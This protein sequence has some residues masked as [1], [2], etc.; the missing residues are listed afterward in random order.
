MAVTH[1]SRHYFINNCFIKDGFLLKN[2]NKISKKPCH[3]IQGRHDVICPP[4]S[5]YKLSKIWDNSA[6]KLVEDGAHSGFE[7]SMFSEI[8]KSVNYIII[9]TSR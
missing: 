1:F 3:I 5:A 4:V 6:L 9:D 8:Q 7:E 2:V